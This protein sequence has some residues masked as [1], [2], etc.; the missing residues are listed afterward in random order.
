M[1]VDDG[2]H[3][4][5]VSPHRAQQPAAAAASGG[6]GGGAPRKHTH[7]RLGVE[8]R[9]AARRPA[10]DGPYAAELRKISASALTVLREREGGGRGRA[11]KRRPVRGRRPVGVGEHG[12]RDGGGA[13]A[14]SMHLVLVDGVVYDN[15]LGDAGLLGLGRRPR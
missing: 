12:S 14:T 9:A 4:S 7:R 2:V 11:G 10:D 1:T 8:G 6:D 3:P 15:L 5:V 13:E